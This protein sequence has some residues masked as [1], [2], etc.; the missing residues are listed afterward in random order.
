MYRLAPTLAVLALLLTSASAALAAGPTVERFHETFSGPDEFWT[1]VCQFPVSVSL[2]ERG[3][4]TEYPDG[5]TRFHLRFHA[6]FSGPGGTIKERN[7]FNIFQPEP[8]TVTVDEEAGTR[9]ETFRQTFRGLVV[10]LVVP[11]EG[12]LIRDAGNLTRTLTVVFD[13][14]SGEL[15][16]VRTSDVVIRGPHPSFDMPFEEFA[17]LFCGALA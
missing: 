17:A 9:T 16:D 13:L 12:V 15:I 6:N 3:S 8:T 7:A 1:D 11:G 14:E 10:H 5:S 4:F 2:D